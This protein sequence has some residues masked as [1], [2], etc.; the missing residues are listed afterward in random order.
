MFWVTL[1]FPAVALRIS[2]VEFNGPQFQTNLAILS[3]DLTT[4]AWNQGV[5]GF[6]ILLLMGLIMINGFH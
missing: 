3:L 5:M 6:M 2:I 4:E 1:I